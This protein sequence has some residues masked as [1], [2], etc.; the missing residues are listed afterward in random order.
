MSANAAPVWQ[1]EPAIDFVEGVPAV[2]SI[3]NFVNDPDGAALL[4]TLNSGALLPGIT[5]N[6]NDATLAYDGRPL[7]AK[8]DVPVVVT[9]ITFAA[10]DRMI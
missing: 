3:R 10:D 2:V 1:P 8:A 7:G 4:I 6:P 5:W 9:G